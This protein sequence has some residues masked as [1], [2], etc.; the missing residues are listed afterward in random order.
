MTRQDTPNVRNPLALALAQGRVALAMIVQK[1]PSAD[2]AIAAA[3]SGFDAI[4]IDLE[5]SVLSEAQAAGI[6]LAALYAGVAPLVRVA[7]HEAHTIGRLL[8]A[9]ALGIVAPHVETPD[10]ARAI[11][12]AC[13][14]AP[15]GSR[16]VSYHWPQLG[17][18]TYEPLA[19]RAALDAA[20]SV[21]VMLESPQAIERADEIAA[22]PGVDIVHIG[23]LD[24]SD[25]L[26]VPGRMD[27]PR[28][29]ACFERVIQACRRHG[30]TAGIG[31][32]G[33]H[34]AIARRVIEQGAR[35]LTAGIDWDFMLAAARSRVQSLRALEA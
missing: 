14:F 11:A 1:V 26:G 33:G 10:E 35:F 30:K 27:D 3:S 23:S 9:G 29:L 32:V 34:P 24:L 12:A 19:M 22:V 18:R 8:D 20:T 13:R 2:I 17:Y 4:S 6:S 28:M 5:H 7:S 15:R 21:V 25:A 31:G 16:S